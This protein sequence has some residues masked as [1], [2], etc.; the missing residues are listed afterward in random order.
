[1][2][3]KLWVRKIWAA[4]TLAMQTQGLGRT[5]HSLPGFLVA[6]AALVF[7]VV[8]PAQSPTAPDSVP[9]SRELQSAVVSATASTRARSRV[10]NV[11]MIGQR[12][13]VRAACCNLGES[14]TASPSVDVSYS[15]AAT[16]VGTRHGS[17]G[18]CGNQTKI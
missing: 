7:P 2:I 6:L 3:A 11:E 18:L 13:L 9:Q 12:Q 16:G 15:D 5:A 17:H 10:E 4:C 14:F 8:S 1:M